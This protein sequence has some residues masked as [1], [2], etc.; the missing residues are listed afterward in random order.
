MP[1]DGVTMPVTVVPPFFNGPHSDGPA[2][3]H[4][5]SESVAPG[6]P[7]KLADRISD[8]IVDAALEQNPRARVAVETLVTAGRCVVAGEV[9]GTE[10]LDFE[11]LARRAIAE[12]GYLEPDFDARTVPVEVLVHE[13]SKEIASAVDISGG[14]EGAGDQGMMFGYA[15]R[16]TPELMPAPILYAHRLLARLDELRRGGERRLGLDGKAQVTLRYSGDA[17]VEA[18]AIVVSHQHAEGA[19]EEVKELFLKTVEEVI[20]A[21]LRNDRTKLLLNP[22]GSFVIGGPVADTGLTGRKIIVDTYGGAAPHGGGAFSGKD[23]SKV[24]RSAAYAARWLAKNVVSSG[25]ADRC[26][27]QLAWAIGS[28][29]PLVLDVETFGTSY[30]SGP[31]IARAIERCVELS[32]KGL[33]ERLGLAQPIYARTAAFGHFGRA[34][35]ADGGFS[36]ERTDL[37]EQLLGELD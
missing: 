21:E 27:V 20:P 29:R 24:D 7:D 5:T 6:H 12:V 10:G 25:I 37:G 33:R 28:S 2:T 3:S 34:P 26:L 15:C 11:A 32:V 16:E 36:W 22:S 35:E 30:E 13:Q 18:L 1:R 23:P 9:R 4:L 8:Q 14:E 19:G 31:I 17:P